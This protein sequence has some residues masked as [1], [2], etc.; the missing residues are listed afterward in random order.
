MKNR[1]IG[2]LFIIYLSVNPVWA[3]ERIVFTP[4]WT[5]QAEFT[6]YYVAKEKGFYKEVGLD[7]EI[8]HPTLAQPVVDRILNGDCHATTLQLCQAMELIDKGVSLVNVLQTSMNEGLVILSAR[9]KN[10]FSQKGARIAVANTGFT[11]LAMSICEKEGFDFQWIP[12][13]R[14]V[15]LYLAGAV[16]AILG[17][18]FNELYVLRQSGVEL[19]E[20]SLY[21][22][23]DHG[24]NIQGEGVYMTYDYYSKHRREARNFAQASRRGWEWAAQHP[25]EAIEIVSKYIKA[26]RI[27]TNRELQ[28]LMLKEILRLQIDRETGKRE[29]KL[30]PA[31]VKRASQLMVEGGMLSREIGYLELIER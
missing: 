29:F 25:D 21:R 12:A 10:L 11:H 31:M 18:S 15:N 16:D 14:T 28:R 1:L 27:A 20:S 24:Y 4:Q 26:S 22:F 9:G 19:P 7:V 5:A 13:A 6:G 8:I 23:S 3:Q 17:M 30:R 2:F